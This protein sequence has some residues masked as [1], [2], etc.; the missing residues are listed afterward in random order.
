[1]NSEFD[2]QINNN[3]IQYYANVKY[4]FPLNKLFESKKEMAAILLPRN[5]ERRVQELAIQNIKKTN[6]NVRSDTNGNNS[7]INEYENKIQREIWPVQCIKCH[8]FLKN[9]E[10][11]NLHMNDHW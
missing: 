11:F 3:L 1:M 5:S 10:S 7:I 8:I 6:S 9:L 2:E 4:Q